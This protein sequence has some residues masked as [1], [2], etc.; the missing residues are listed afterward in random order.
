MIITPIPTT[1]PKQKEIY[2]SFR[3]RAV[4]G[5]TDKQRQELNTEWMAASAAREK[6]WDKEKQAIRDANATAFRAAPAEIWRKLEDTKPP[7]FTMGDML[8]QRGIVQLVSCKRIKGERGVKRGVG[9][10][11]PYTASPYVIVVRIGSWLYSDGP[12][13]FHKERNRDYVTY[14]AVAAALEYIR[15]FTK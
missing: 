9:T 15:K 14:A 8:V 6:Q 4:P 5:M 2:E 7:C 1:D 11:Y 13:Y 3:A 10:D 12:L